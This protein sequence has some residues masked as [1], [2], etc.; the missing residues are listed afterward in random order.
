MARRNIALMGKPYVTEEGVASEA[1]TPGMLVKGVTTIAKQS[2]AALN[3][4]RAF[5]LE[6][7]EL[8]NDID[9]A[10]ASGDVVKVGVFNGGQRVYALI[11]SGQNITADG[12][13]EAAADG[14]LR[15]L[16][17]GV[18]I[19]RA[20]ESVNNAAGPSNARLRVEVI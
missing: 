11:A 1:I 3:H 10:Y 7:E 18:A 9:T 2:V 14:T 19:A 20:L 5:A 16:N 6:R 4:P 13:L 12:K 8:G 17:S 15:A